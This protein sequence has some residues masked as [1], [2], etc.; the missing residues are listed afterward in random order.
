M[1]ASLALYLST[2]SQAFAGEAWAVVTATGPD[3]AALQPAL[4][5][6]LGAGLP[7]H[8]DFP[9]LADAAKLG[10]VGESGWALVVALPAEEQ[11]AV[12]LVAHLDAR[13][14]DARVV[15]A[16]SA[17][18]QDVRLLSLDRVTASGNGAPLFVWSACLAG[19]DPSGCYGDARPDGEGRLMIPY[20]PPSEKTAMQL[21]IDPGD[22]WI[23]NGV[24]L[25]LPREGFVWRRGPTAASCYESAQPKK[26]SRK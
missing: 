22:P 13:Q 15:R 11:V 26:R 10:L 25:G 21:L 20:V 2:C 17:D 23:C 7:K 19:A 16:Q 1:I 8:G 14:V 24:T 6:Y 3:Q 4:Q 5:E 9:K 18:A 12:E